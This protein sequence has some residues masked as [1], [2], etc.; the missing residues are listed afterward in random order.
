MDGNGR[1]AENLGKKR[2]IGHKE[3]AQ[4]V[5]NITIH[6]S[7]INLKY[8]TLYAFSTENWKRPRHEIEFLMKLL[9]NYLAKELDTYLKHNV[10]FNAIGDISKFSKKLRQRIQETIEKTKHCDG[11]TQTLAIN[12]GSKNEII[13]AVKKIKRV[14]DID[15]ET[16]EKLLD[17]RD[18]PPVDMLIR[19]GGKLRIS[20][21]LLWQIAYAELFFTK[22]L[23]P[24]F[25]PKEFDGFIEQFKNIKRNFGAV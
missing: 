4:I 18:L 8:L 15:E 16:F 11:L 1:W 6:S 17:T 20:N 22:T 7:N 2:T 5:R 9:D 3:G 13:R 24:D 14:E 23:W 19:T 12:Y 21:F 10:K 25:N